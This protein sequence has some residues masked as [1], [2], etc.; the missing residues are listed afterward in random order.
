MDQ[1][2][3]VRIEDVQEI[4]DYQEIT[5]VPYAPKF[6]KG[7]LDLR[8]EIVPVIELSRKFGHKDADAYSNYKLIV[9]SLPN[10]QVGILVND[11]TEVTSIN[12]AD[13]RKPPALLSHKALA[14]II[15]LNN[16]LVILLNVENILQKEDFDLLEDISKLDQ[17]EL[18]QLAKET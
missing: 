6:V 11:V 8:G 14:G 2:F 1:L 16:R 3:G 5:P 12:E 15:K 17:E 13:I 18:A 10:Q 9:I 7:I 4:L